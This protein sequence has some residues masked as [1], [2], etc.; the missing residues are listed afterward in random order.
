VPRTRTEPGIPLGAIAAILAS[1]QPP[2]PIAPAPP[3]AQ[4]SSPDPLG[5]TL[6][7]GLGGQGAPEGLREP[8][9]RRIAG[10]VVVCFLIGMMGALFAL[11][12]LNYIGSGVRVGSLD[13][14][15]T[16]A[17]EALRHARWDTP[18]GDNVRDLTNAALAKWPH[19]PRILELRARATDELVKEAVGRK[20]GGDLA[21]A[22]HWARLANELD[23]TDTTAQHLVEEYQRAGA[24]SAVDAGPGRPRPTPVLPSAAPSVPSHASPHV[25]PPSSATPG[26]PPRV[27]FEASLAHP[28]VGQPVSLTAKVLGAKAVDEARFLINGPGLTAD[29]KLGTVPE[30]N[31]AYQTTF[32]GFEPGKYDITF[33]AKID[34]TLS[35]AARTLVIDAAPGPTAPSSTPSLPPTVP[36]GK[37]L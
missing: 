26:A 25:T 6:D 28:H 29:T 34:G 1:P 18:P 19:E 21:G 32:T 4:P 14:A 13:A 11:Y 22:L 33:E 31:G 24:E 16:Q 23:P 8:L 5:E 3:A 17:D 27:A 35:R 10:V 9:R 36:S 2:S 7:E 12:Q 20:F 37:W 30:A 15:V